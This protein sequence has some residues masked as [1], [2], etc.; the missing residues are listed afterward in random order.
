MNVLIIGA[1]G[2]T[3]KLVVQRAQAAGHKVTAFVH[4]PKSYTAPSPGVRVV[5]GD[6]RD[7]ASVGAAMAGQDAVI[8]TIGG[9]KPFLT[10]DL[11]Q[12]AAK[13][14]VGA[15]KQTGTRRLI[16]ISALGVGDSKEQS[17]F[18]YEHVFLP[19]F[20]RGSTKD[21]AAMEQ[22][23]EKSG[24]DFVVVRPAILDDGGASGAVRVF[25]GDEKA[26][27][28][29]RADVAQFV[30]DQLRSDRYVGEAVTIASS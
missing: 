3:G 16:V 22:A 5:G 13:A 12:S 30:V 18:F 29:S 8:D 28:I 19:T 26:H 10:S 24:V 11:E 14:I 20:L 27:K 25:E 4:D 23:V 9:K 6:A 7:Q 1:A 15:M 2:K 17:G 21:K